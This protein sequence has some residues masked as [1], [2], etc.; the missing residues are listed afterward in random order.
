ML[1]SYNDELGSSTLPVRRDT[2]ASPGLTTRHEL[3]SSP[4]PR[5]SQPVH[6]ARAPEAFTTLP[7]GKTARQ[8]PSGSP[9]Q[10][11]AGQQLANSA[12][13]QNHPNRPVPAAVTQP[14][15]ADSSTPRNNLIPARQ[16]TSTWLGTT[17]PSS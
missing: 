1:V 8:D 13:A 2:T 7:H 4:A 12:F 3:N 10:R 11:A 15:Q 16:D 5:T 6:A 14:G 17:S 9:A